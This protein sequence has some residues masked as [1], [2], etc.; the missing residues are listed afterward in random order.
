MTH[1]E[2]HKVIMAKQDE[3]IKGTQVS[4]K[5]AV[6]EEQV[7]GL[8]RQIEVKRMQ[9]NALIGAVA[10]I[11]IG[12]FGYIHGTFES[13]DAA[14]RFQDAMEIEIQDRKDYQQR[15]ED[16]IDNHIAKCDE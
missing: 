12:F 9:S 6:L 2:E 4:S 8:Q 1:E 10:T 7:K 16:K 5:V 13:K 3:I 15:T 14:Q 11:M